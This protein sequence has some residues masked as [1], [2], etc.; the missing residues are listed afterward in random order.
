MFIKLIS[1]KGDLC[2]LERGSRIFENFDS[3]SRDKEILQSG[4]QIGCTLESLWF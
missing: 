2:R 4:Y 1:I 3:N